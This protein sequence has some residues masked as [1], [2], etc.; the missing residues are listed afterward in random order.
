[1]PHSL[2]IKNAKI[3]D[4]TGA[5]WFK[6]DVAIDQDKIVG[7]G[8]IK[9]IADKIID[10][11]GFLVSPGWIDVHNHADHTILGNPEAL[12]YVHQGVTTVTM[13]NCGLSMYPL[14][15]EYRSDLI[16]YMKPFTAGIPFKYDWTNLEEF[17]QRITEIGTSINLVPF[18]GHGSIR[19]ATMGFANRAPTDSELEQMKTYL[20]ES[21][22]HGSYG[23]STGLG[24]PPGL[25]SDN[26]EL[27]ALSEV[28][29]KYRG[30]YSTHMR[31]EDGNLADT[32]NLGRAMKVP[33]QVSHLGSSCGSRASLRGRH[34]TTTLKELDD[35]RA[36]GVDIT[37]D[38]YPYIAG[39]SL[40]SQVIPDWLH[41]GG[42]PKMLEK[43]KDPEVQ[44][45]MAK[46]YEELG[47]DFSKII[48]SYVKSADNK[49]IEGMSIAAIAEKWEKNIVDTVCKLMS[50]EKGEAMNIT[51]WG[52]EEDVDTMI[53][54]PAVMPC[55]DGWIL[56]PTGP[57]GAGKPHP[58]CY[59]AFPRYI[60][61]Y[62]KQKKILGL[63]EGIRRMTSMPATRLGIQDRG[64]IRAGMKADIT[65]FNLEKI[66]DT[67]TFSDPHRYPEGIEYV[68]IN[69]E[70]T[71][72]KGRHTGALSGEILKR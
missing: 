44:A 46:E 33:V 16:D 20:A 72:E 35:A 45:Q 41:E 2:L 52:T 47:R 22:K 66:K 68:I 50:D 58:R 5:P 49:D 17:K 30:I 59:G 25:Y 62:V 13:G 69:G 40:L 21:M 28:L 8:K 56:A 60:D 42:V 3:I 14:S 26:S 57:L 18:I 67:A 31:G 34:E 7:I 27:I 32:I 71:V 4:G 70:T 38:I 64:I 9:D 23:M 15:E 6:A 29:R 55:S 12:S 19:I 63:E 10:V 48:V 51:F 53:R 65:I 61:Q 39:S 1:M 36:E 11:E 54:H 24:Y 37:A 43:L